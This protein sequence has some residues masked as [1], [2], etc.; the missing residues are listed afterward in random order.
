MILHVKQLGL[1]QSIALFCITV[2]FLLNSLIVF[3][4][5]TLISLLFQLLIISNKRLPLLRVRI[6]D[7]FSLVCD[8]V[9]I[10]VACRLFWISFIVS[11]GNL[12]LLYLNISRRHSFSNSFSILVILLF[13]NSLLV[14]ELYLSLNKILIAFFVVFV[15]FLFVCREATY[16]I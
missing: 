5:L 7:K 14:C 3:K 2:I 16:T 15:A 4:S 9:P 10:V 6:G 12:L 1:K 11:F 8:L 13:S